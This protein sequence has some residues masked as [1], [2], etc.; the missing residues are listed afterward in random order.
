[1]LQLIRPQL[2]IIMCIDRREW[3]TNVIRDVF[4]KH[5]QTC[6][7]SISLDESNREDVLY[8]SKKNM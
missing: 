2:S 3:D 7:L 4:N 6:I 1:M 8:W 5:D